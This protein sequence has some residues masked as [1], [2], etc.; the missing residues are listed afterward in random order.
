MYEEKSV[1]LKDKTVQKSVKIELTVLSDF[2]IPIHA[3]PPGVRGERTP[4]LREFCLTVTFSR[5]EPTNIRCTPV[6][7]YAR[8]CVRP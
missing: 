6:T 3:R 8:D 7:V 5:N 4:F 1:I 2:N